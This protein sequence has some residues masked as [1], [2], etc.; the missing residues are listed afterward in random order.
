LAEKIVEHVPCAEAVT[1]HST[2]SEATFFALRLARAF[3]RRD[4]ILKFEGGYHGMGD[5]AL[6]STQWTQA[7]APF[8][9]A[10]PSSSGIPASVVSEVLVAPFNDVATTTAIIERHHNAI[11]AVIVEPLQRTI[12]PLPGFLAELRRITAHYGILLVFDEVVTGFRLGLGG[13]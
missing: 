13:A 2:G 1:F 11:A 7:P 9:M 12:P 5:H 10:T 8:P 3:R 4:T 6:M